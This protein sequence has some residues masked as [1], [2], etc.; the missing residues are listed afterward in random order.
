MNEL[1]LIN[2][3]AITYHP[4]PAFSSPLSAQEKVDAIAAHFQEIMQILGLDTNHPSLSKTPDRIANMYIHELFRGLDTTSFPDMTYVDNDV[5][6]ETQGMILVKGIPVKSTCEHHFVPIIGRAQVAYIP[7][8][9]ILGLS[10]INRI[11]DYFCRRPQL[12]ER[13]TAQIADCLSILLHTEDVAVVIEAEHFCVTLRGVEHPSSRTLTTCL[14]G[15]FHNDP[16]Y[17][18]TLFNNLTT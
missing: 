15:I 4:Q 14:R 11:V 16:L 18:T 5:I 13:L 9:L 3:A 17:K 7:N 12:Q 8:Q 10:K 1:D 6:E 2:Q